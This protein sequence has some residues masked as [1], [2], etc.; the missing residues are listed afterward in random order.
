[1]RSSFPYAMLASSILTDMSLTVTQSLYLENFAAITVVKCNDDAVSMH[2]LQPLLDTALVDRVLGVSA[3][4]G[5]NCQLSS[6]AFSTLSRA[7]VVNISERH[8]SPA[9]NKRIARNRTLIQDRLLLNPDF[10]KYAF[11]MD[12]IAVALFQDLSIRI[13]DAVDMMSV[14]TTDNRHSL[15][16]LMNTMG[17]E[18]VLDKKNVQS[19]F[20]N[21]E[22][23]TMDTTARALKAWA[24]YRAATHRHVS[25]RFASLP[26]IDTE[27]F[28]RTVRCFARLSVA[29]LTRH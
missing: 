14:S 17:G 15:Q 22:L 26:R 28:P 18:T 4:F 21:T 11:W 2:H 25:S 24:A 20:F 3:T 8:T 19:L 9:V 5:Q 10:R 23:S 29:F 13:R 16:A 7:L 27:A 6:I 12:Q 1:M